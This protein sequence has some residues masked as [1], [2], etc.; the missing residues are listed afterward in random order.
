MV[1]AL[2]ILR[3]RSDGQLRHHRGCGGLW[4]TMPHNLGESPFKHDGPS[5]SELIG[6]CTTVG[7]NATPLGMRDFGVVRQM[8]EGLGHGMP[9]DFRKPSPSGSKEGKIRG[10]QAR[11]ANRNP[12][13]EDFKKNRGAARLSRDLRPMKA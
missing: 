11:R 5:G 4:A 13:Y 3:R 8:P 1:A 10:V 2:L 6:A 7:A 9:D 12:G